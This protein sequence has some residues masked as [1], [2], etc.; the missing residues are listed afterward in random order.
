MHL[1]LPLKGGRISYRKEN[2]YFPLF[3]QFYLLIVLGIKCAIGMRKIL[4]FNEYDD[5]ISFIGS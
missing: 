5:L 2:I 4:N 3:V 1:H